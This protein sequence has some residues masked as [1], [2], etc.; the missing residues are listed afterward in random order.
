MKLTRISVQ[1]YRSFSERTELDLSGGMNALVGPNNCGKSNFL[2]AVAMALDPDYDFDRR[3]DVPGQRRNA[4]PR[5]TLTFQCEGAT[6]AE[7][8]LLRYAETYERSVSGFKGSTYA[9]DGI[10]RFVVSYR[11]AQTGATRQEYFAARG[12]GDLRG[13]ADLNQKVL[14][15]FRKISRFVVV[16]SGQRLSSLLSGKFRE[17]L[18]AVLKEHLREEFADAVAA[19]EQYVVGLQ[20]QLLAPMREKVLD[21]AVRLFPEICDIDLIPSVSSIEETLS[22][23]E[24]NIRDSF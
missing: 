7:K 12:V 10:L 5:S 4:F 20:K 13:D 15:Q 21:V 9:Q 1:N 14:R 22:N 23:V 2:S 3:H 18:H 8:T 17:I 16:D 11:L 6:P 19:R 24:I